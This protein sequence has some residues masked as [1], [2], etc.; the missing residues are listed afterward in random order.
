MKDRTFTNTDANVLS[1]VTQI[2][3]GFAVTLIDVDSESIVMTRIY[4]YHLGKEAVAY[5][6]FLARAI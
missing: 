5:A 6:K 3:D 1:L 2:K 4:P